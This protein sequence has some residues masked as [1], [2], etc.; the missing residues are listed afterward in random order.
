M[1]ADLTDSTTVLIAGRVQLQQ[2]LM[3]LILNGTEA[4]HDTIGELHTESQLDGR[5]NALIPISDTGVGFP[6]ETASR[7]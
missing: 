5:E 2:A 7:Y 3:N 4:M 1:N 6:M